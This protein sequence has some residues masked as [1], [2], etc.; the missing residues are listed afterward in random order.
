M[1]VETHPT[2]KRVR[3]T[4]ML[5]PEEDIEPRLTLDAE[6]FPP[7]E[8]NKMESGDKITLEIRCTVDAVIKQLD[9]DTPTRA[10][11]IIKSVGMA[12]MDDLTALDV[13]RRIESKTKERD[14]KGRFVKGK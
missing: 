9:Q 2:K 11:F 12:D 8:I 10:T 6:Q 1:A 7:I 3:L 14:A 13:E 4:P 5:Q